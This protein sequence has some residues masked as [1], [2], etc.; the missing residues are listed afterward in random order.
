MN[1]LETLDW[2]K[3]KIPSYQKMGL[4]NNTYK[5]GLERITTICKYLGNPQE[6]FKSIHIGGTNGKGSTINMLY[7]IFIEEGYKVG[8]FTSPHLIDFRERI[9][10]NGNYIDK[11]FIIN[12]IKKNKFF[13][14]KE[15]ISFF[16]MN[17]AMAFQYFK[18]KKIDIALIEVGMGGRLDSTNIINPII[19]IITNISIDHT[20][21]LGN[22][23]LK[24][25]NEKSGIIKKTIP[26]VIGK[27]V[28]KIVRKFFFKCS[29]KKNSPIYFVPKKFL[30]KNDNYL[31]NVFYQ[32]KNKYLVLYIINILKIKN[33]FLSENSINKGLINLEKNT[34]F[35]GRWSI[36]R[37]EDPKIICD[38]AHNKSGI[39]M[40]NIQLKKES[41]KNLHL[42]L[43]FVKDKKISSFIKYFPNDS[44]YYFCHPN[45]ERK[46]DIKI[47][48]IL[49]EKI[50]VNR[51]RL[52]FFDSVKSAF[53]SAK[54]S[55][56]KNDLILICGS[57]FIVSEIFTLL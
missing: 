34:K 16:E 4:N 5:P 25:A 57:T 24:I 20:E 18:E 29:L 33:I 35:K 36:I 41:Y 42:V 10:C 55:S 52:N 53:F 23:E 17:T 1:Y 30:I 27:D 7:S 50:F 28:S 32:K 2:I 48:K 13:L 6:S 21:S 46:Y 39:S 40:V 11:N 3:N 19:S 54:K 14:E 8:A 22:N 43:G 15:S 12:F 45:I 47:L 49:I 38:V 26:I 51:K 31:N 37:K 44:Y 9:S 56:G